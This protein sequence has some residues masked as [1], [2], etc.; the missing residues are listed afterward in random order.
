MKTSKEL[1]EEFGRL[2]TRQRALLDG[3][4]EAKRSMTAE[5]DQEYGKLEKE[6]GDI[7]IKIQRTERQEIRAAEIAARQSEPVDRPAVDQPSD[8]GARADLS[9]F[10]GL[11]KGQRERME[12]FAALEYRSA[13]A[14]YLAGREEEAEKRALSVGTAAEGGYTVPQEQF[15][16]ELIKSVDNEA[17]IR[18]MARVIQVP[19]AQTLGAPVLDADPADADWTTELETGSEDSTMAFGK[20]ELNPQPVAK[21]L[22][23]SKK[24]LRA[25]PLGMENIV[26]DRLGY[27]LG[28]TQSN[29]FSTGDGA[30][31][32]LGIYT[33][34]AQ[35]IS[36]S[37]DVNVGNGSG[38]VDADGFITA[39]YTLRAGYRPT[40][41]LH[42]LVLA[43]IRKL[44][45]TS[46][47]YLWQPG[48]ANG[49]PPSFLDH[50][51][52]IDEYAPSTISAGNYVAVLGDFSYY[53]IAEALMMEIQRLDELYAATNQVGYIIRAE[54]DAM[55]V[56][57]DAFVRCT[58]TA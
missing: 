13:F 19:Q 58:I 41:H 10:R 4:E 50:P 51:Y 56:L 35:G 22:K 55:P 15:V 34:S 23:V 24:L 6:I 54:V 45:A 53:W 37:R 42:R 27:K 38:G 25:S 14:A 20:R 3:A 12:Q 33:A 44:K 17:V 30:S 2:V 21:L 29:A 1:R 39:R 46:G 36:T 48:L 7:E 8:S 18:P 49:T 57:E 28:V 16:R 31:K 40:W 26:R 43:A 5:E 52:V 47:D 32:P 11:T 9:Q